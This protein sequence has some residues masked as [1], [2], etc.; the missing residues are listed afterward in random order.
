VNKGAWI[1]ALAGGLVTLGVGAV[2]SAR[3]RIGKAASSMSPLPPTPPAH[4][5]APQPTPT[6]ST[7]GV[8]VRNSTIYGPGASMPITNADALWLGRAI[9]G[10][11]SPRRTQQARAAV[12]WALAQNLMLVGRRSTS[13]APR[14]SNF[15]AMVR[16]YCQP[17]NERWATLD[18]PGCRQSPR[19]CQPYHLERRAIYRNLTWGELTPDVRQVVEQ[20]RAGTLANPVPGAVDWHANA[21]AGAT[22]QIGGNHFGTRPGRLVLQADTSGILR[23]RRV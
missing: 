5:P 9:T 22:A 7:A 21:Y 23:G 15:T 4:G 17:V 18:S 20:F 2:A 16:A 3:G 12:A 11:V 6:P 8:T 1:A 14:Y 10:E 13:S 19:N